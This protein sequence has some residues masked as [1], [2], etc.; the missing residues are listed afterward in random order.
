MYVNGYVLGIIGGSIISFVSLITSSIIG[1]Y[2][3]RLT[4]AGLKTTTELKSQLFLNKYGAMAVLLTRGIPI[5][6]ESVCLVSGYNKMPFNQYLIYNVI[7]YIPLCILYAYC[8]SLGYDKNIFL[9]SFGC[10]LLIS[11]L[12]WFVGKSIIKKTA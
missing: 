1:Y 3:G 7:G 11:A 4:S 10:S 6:S 2:L 12:F 9:F 5:L 8:G